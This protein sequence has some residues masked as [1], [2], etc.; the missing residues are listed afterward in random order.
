MRQVIVVPKNSDIRT[1]EQ[2]K[3]KRVAMQKESTAMDAFIDSDIPA[4]VTELESG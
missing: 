4:T 3:D 2:M 1:P